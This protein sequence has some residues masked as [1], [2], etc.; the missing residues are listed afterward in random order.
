MVSNKPAYASRGV[1]RRPRYQYDPTNQENDID[2]SYGLWVLELTELWHAVG[3]RFS[4]WSLSF[5]LLG[6]DM[7]HMYQLICRNRYLSTVMSQQ[8]NSFLNILEFN[9]SDNLKC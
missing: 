6:Y 7:V 9:P 4:P 5:R 1:K 3:W 2:A 8:Q